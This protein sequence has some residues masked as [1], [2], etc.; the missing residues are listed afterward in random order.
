MAMPLFYPLIALHGMG[1]QTN[2]RGNASA[3]YS[4]TS[5]NPFPGKLLL[6][7]FYAASVIVTRASSA[8]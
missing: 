7:K 5:L 2:A 1:R 3:A 8:F 6:F 4:L